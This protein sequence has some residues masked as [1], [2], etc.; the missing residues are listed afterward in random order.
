MN[1]N[2]DG[3]VMDMTTVEAKN[4][5]TVGYNE[6]KRSLV[7]EFT[8]GPVYVYDEVP[9][10][11]YEGMLTASSPDDYYNDNFKTGYANR[12]VW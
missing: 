6:E 3:I 9:K 2:V 8:R 11:V 7:I 1:K 10:S 5:L 12:R 4:I